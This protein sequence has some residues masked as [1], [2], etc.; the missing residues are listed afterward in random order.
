M[1]VSNGIRMKLEVKP[2]GR[3]GWVLPPPPEPLESF[4]LWNIGRAQKVY[5]PNESVR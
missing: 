2:V 1:Y 5:R 3:A 4:E